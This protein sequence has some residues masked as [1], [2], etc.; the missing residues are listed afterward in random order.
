M[1]LITGMN[2]KLGRALTLEGIARGLPLCGVVRNEKAAEQVQDLVKKG[3]KLFIADLSKREAIRELIQEITRTQSMPDRIILNAATIEDDIFNCA[4]A[5]GLGEIIFTNL[6]GPLLLISGLLPH[7]CENEGRVIA[8]SSLSGRLATDK[9]RIA[10]PA[11]KAGLSMAFS[12]LRLQ[13]ELDRVRFITVEPGLMGDG[14]P[15]LSI[16]YARA[17]KRIMN[18]VEAKNPKVSVSFPILSNLIYRIMG[19]LPR[20]ITAGIIILRAKIKK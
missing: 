20:K 15:F 7:L 14:P 8:I 16:S 19:N 3:A 5:E 9:G 18:L 11:S 1:L 4:L 10:Y 2:G 12:A 6:T 13:P 17:A